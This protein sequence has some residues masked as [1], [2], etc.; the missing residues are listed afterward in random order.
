M[1]AEE[2][3]EIAAIRAEEKAELAALDEELSAAHT[4]AKFNAHN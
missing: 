1:T 2:K 3:A 4:F